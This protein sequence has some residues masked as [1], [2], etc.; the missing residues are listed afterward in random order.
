MMGS[1]WAD[2]AVPLQPR[3][4][5]VR[6]PGRS[7]AR[8]LT[9]QVPPP[10]I[11]V[12]L[13]QAQ[14]AAYVEALRTCGVEVTALPPDERFPDGCFVQDLAVLYEDVAVICRPGAPSRQGEEVAVEEALAPHKRL[15]RIQP[16][17][18]LEGGDV[19]RVGRRLFVGL[20]ARTNQAGFAQLRDAL[21]P[22]GATV[23]P[24]PVEGGLHLMTGCAYLG[25]G[26]LLA[27]GSRAGRPEFLGLDVIFV[28]PEEAYAA[29]CLA[30]GDW[31]ILPEGYPRVRAALEERGFRVLPVPMSEFQRADGGVTC[32][33]LLW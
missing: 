11:N 14:H 5:L 25:R 3:H 16:P 20:S 22:L 30:V 2:V 12:A 29:N 32:L 10:R 8:A 26:M 24:V 6:P 15:V 31:A 33:S 18:T 1:Q 27:A 23:L 17:G 28:P 4:A 9:A 19:L 13:A 7:F 21:E